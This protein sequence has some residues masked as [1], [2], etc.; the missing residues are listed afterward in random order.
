MGDSGGYLG[1]GAGSSMRVQT[2]TGYVD[3]GST[4]AGWAH[5]STDRPGYY[6]NRSIHVDGE[7]QIYN[8]GT[9]LNSSGMFWGSG[10]TNLTATT[11]GIFSL[12][13]P[14]LEN[15]VTLRT[16]SGIAG[17]LYG[18][19]TTEM[20]FLDRNA[21]WSFRVFKDQDRADFYVNN[22][23]VNNA[24]YHAGG[25]TYANGIRLE[26]ADSNMF[27]ITTSAN[28]VYL[29][30]VTNDSTPRGYVFADN[31]NNIGFLDQVGNWKLRV[32]PAGMLHVADGTS[33]SD[34][35]VKRNIQPIQNALA[36]VNKL[37]GNTYDQ[38][39]MG[40]R[41]AGPI[42]QEVEIVLPEAVSADDKG[43][44][45]VSQMGLIALL[46][47]AVKELSTEVDTLKRR[48]H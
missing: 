15:F 4:N 41:R 10:A 44:L 9:G 11:N 37:T 1:A 18:Y 48:L 35:R 40:I 21:T 8:T 26:A 27:K 30:L 28:Y 34:R 24:N 2:P 19:S 43:K 23:Y 7:L 39:E 45:A 32:D 36:K 17:Y 5:F 6:F 31:S 25:I 13:S 38:I 3:V 16:S 33:T 29:A 46:I 20:G 22:L 42:A 47:E 14:N 12:T